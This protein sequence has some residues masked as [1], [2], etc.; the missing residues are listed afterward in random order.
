MCVYRER[1]WGW[2][3]SKISKLIGQLHNLAAYKTLETCTICF[4]LF[5]WTYAVY[6]SKHSLD[7]SVNFTYTPYCSYRHD[8]GKVGKLRFVRQ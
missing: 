7:V 6:S 2:I 3:L 5:I 8:V 1:V 4:H